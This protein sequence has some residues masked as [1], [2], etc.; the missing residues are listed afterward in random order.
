MANIQV[1]KRN[2]KIVSF[3]FRVFVG[4]DNKGRQQ[5]K[6]KIWKPDGEYTEKRLLKLAEAEATLWEREIV[7]GDSIPIEEKPLFIKFRDFVNEEW[8][9]SLQNEDCRATT[10]E[11][12]TYLLQTILPYFGTILISE[13][14]SKKARAYLDYLKTNRE[15]P[16]GKP[17]SPQ[18]RKHH[19]STLNLIF[20]YAIQKGYITEN[21]MKDIEPPKLKRHKVDAFTKSEVTRFIDEVEKLPLM[22][23]TMYY[24]LLTTGVRRGECFG[25][26]W[27]DIDFENA[28]VHINRNVVYTTKSGAVVGAPKTDTGYRTIPLANKTLLLLAEYK[29]TENPKVKD[30]FLFHGEGAQTEPRDPS[31]LTKHMKKLMKKADLPNMSPHDLRHTCASLL[32]QNGAD[33]KS[34]QDILGHADARTTLN[35]YARSDIAQM[36]NSLEATFNFG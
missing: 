28:L 36:R 7:Q 33:I 5:F 23:K 16:K 26:Q 34:V 9:P 31:Y 21:P 18:T 27:G 15:N 32:L 29:I 3:R 30:A 6:T 35:F 8:L 20:K 2:G 10:Y 24:I 25:L 4:R 14:D 12:R 22:Q 13:I 19:H 11:F 1:N 17:L